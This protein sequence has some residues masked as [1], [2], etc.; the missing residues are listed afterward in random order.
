MDCH[1]PPLSTPPPESP[2]RL[3]SQLGALFLSHVFRLD[4]APLNL[5]TKE[6]VIFFVPPFIA[7]HADLIFVR[8]LA[9]VLVIPLDLSFNLMDF[10]NFSSF[11]HAD[12]ILSRTLAVNEPFKLATSV[13]TFLLLLLTL[14]QRSTIFFRA[15]LSALTTKL[16]ARVP[17][18]FISLRSNSGIDLTQLTTD[19]NFSFRPS[20]RPSISFLPCSFNTD[21]L[22]C[23]PK[24]F[25]NPSK[26]GL[27]I[28]S[29]IHVLTFL[30]PCM[31]PSY[32]PLT[33]FPPAS[34]ICLSK[35][36]LADLAILFATSANTAEIAP[37]IL[38]ANLAPALNNFFHLMPTMKSTIAFPKFFH[39]IVSNR[40]DTK[41]NAVA[42]PS[43][44]VL[45]S[46]FQ[47]RFSMKPFRKVP[48][49][50]AI[51]SR[52]LFIFFHGIFSR[53]SFIFS[54]TILPNQ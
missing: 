12:W 8:A 53:A 35:Y 29:Y 30:M 17:S 9:S 31:I 49:L 21:E 45:A 39:L 3:R 13:S 15:E 11:A 23:I 34:L 26:N 4:H 6:R 19:L 33:T 20:S 47:S 41:L 18:L 44:I 37:R 22:V 42:I 5:S 24:A 1:P 28:L 2:T 43:E 25:R 40:V 32:R 48:M 27:K 16:T 50:F 10:P 46:N 14:F 52:V 38:P 7:D 54:A 36:F 51:F